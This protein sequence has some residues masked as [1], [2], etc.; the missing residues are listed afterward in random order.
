MAYKNYKVTNNANTILFWDISASATS[1][2]CKAWEWAL[3]PTEFPYLLTLEKYSGSYV[4]KRE[5]IEVT[6][7]V[8]DLFTIVRHA[9]SCVQDDTADPK[10]Q[11]QNWLSFSD[12][13]WITL[14]MVAEMDRDIA[15]EL[16]KKAL[17]TEVVKKTWN[18]TID[19]DLTVDNIIWNWSWLTWINAEVS[20][21]TLQY[22]LWAA[23][24][25]SKGYSLWDYEQLDSDTEV[26]IWTT[27]QSSVA[28]S[29]Y[30]QATY[31][32]SSLP[33]MVRKEWSPD[34]WIFIEIQTDNAWVP[35]WT[36]VTNWISDTIDYT[37][38]SET[39]T[40]ENFTFPLEVSLT[41]WELYHIV[42]K[43]S[44]SNSD[45][46]H[47]V[48]WSA[49]SDEQ[50]WT[51]STN[52]WASW[53]NQTNDLYFKLP[54]Y[55][56]LTLWWENVL[57][58]LQAD[59]VIWTQWKVNT[60]YDNNQ[61]WLTVWN[62][63]SV[64]KITWAIE[65]WTDYKAI[66]ETELNLRE[67]N[68]Q[69]TKSE[70]ITS[71]DILSWEAIVYDSWYFKWDALD[72]SKI[73]FAGF[74]SETI[75]SWNP[76]KLDTAWVNSNQSWLVVWV[77]YFLANEWFSYNWNNLDV[78]WK[79]TTPRWVTFKPDWTELYLAWD[80]SN[81][82][83]QYTLSA[84]WD[85]S[86]ATFTATKAIAEDTSPSWITFNPTGTKCFINWWS[87][88]KI[89][90]YSLWIAYDIST[91]SYDTIT[92]DVSW[93]SAIASNVIFNDDW[94][95]I[96]IIDWVTLTVYQY[97]LPTPYILT[98]WSYASKSLD[99]WDNWWLWFNDDWTV[100]YVIWTTR[101]DMRS[102]SLSVAY[103]VSTWWSWSL[104]I[105]TT[106]ISTTNTW[107]FI[108]WTNLYIVSAWS[109]SIYEYKFKETWEI[110]PYPWTNSVKVWKA[111][112]STE[113]EIYTWGKEV[114]SEDTLSITWELKMW[115]TDSAPSWWLISD[116]SAISRAAYSD[117][118]DVIWTTYWTWDWSTTFNIPN[119]T[120]NVPVWKDTW[121][122]SSLWWTGWA[123]THTLTI[124][125]M[126][127]HNHTFVAS[128]EDN[129]PWYDAWTSHSDPVS[130]N[131]S[132]V[133]WNASHNNL[134]PYIVINYIIK[135]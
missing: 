19:W 40:E 12:W 21:P 16:N 106:W 9:A 75:T 3:F 82:I 73:N 29:F 61:S 45:V 76:L 96:Y 103:D 58:V 133:W 102:F 46:N 52:D 24:E 105:D 15:E 28:Q 78:S 42:V 111:I 71:E 134:Q 55:K 60:W 17:E 22:M 91:L 98:G 112:S 77:E 124:A 69:S 85:V 57:W 121:T 116:W 86:T 63:Y 66:S 115:T 123:E 74:A 41:V 37:N 109:D 26:N 132:S 5:I 131:T 92:L 87:W 32:W 23:W 68:R 10:V 34:D 126:P 4:I 64:N 90:Q 2:S 56:L 8:D 49:W 99:V 70:I 117:L 1:F 122:F 25:I 100:L 67:S 11:S 27:G 113:I 84:A 6:N 14:A 53:T 110:A 65:S 50:I 39:L 118:F 95:A 51:L 88:D 79:D 101:Q 130:Q 59:W 107:L 120:G 20:S 44:N 38:I 81:S 36:A 108:Q 94:T 30:W 83:H 13:D 48:V 18:Q 127:N 104:L 135:T 7:R 62:F 72:L 43:R 35:S 129:W 54:W 47:Y 125:Q 93:E 114:I 97:T 128:V 89:Y 31:T 80:S 33:L 119:L